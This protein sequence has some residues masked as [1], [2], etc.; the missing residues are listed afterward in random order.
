MGRTIKATYGSAFTPCTVL[1]F[2]SW[3]A[4][5]GARIVNKAPSA[6]LLVDGVDVETIMDTECFTWPKRIE[7]LDEL[8][9]AVAY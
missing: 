4:V 5:K 2:G 6:D 9:K 8:I 1:V 3:Y 7:S